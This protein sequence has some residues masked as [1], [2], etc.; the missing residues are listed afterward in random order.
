MKGIEAYQTPSDTDFHRPDTENGATLLKWAEHVARTLKGLNTLNPDKEPVLIDLGCG[1]GY[2]TLMLA[3]ILDIKHLVLIDGSN[4]MLNEARRLMYEAQLP[5][6]DFSFSSQAMDLSTD[7]VN[8][9]SGKTAYVTCLAV[10]GF[11]EKLDN[12]F[13]ET[14]RLL[15]PGGLFAFTFLANVQSVFEPKLV[16]HK[17]IDC[18]HH[19]LMAIEA[20]QD[21]FGFVKVFADYKATLDYGD[22]EA[23]LYEMYLVKK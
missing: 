4:A 23:R 1:A 5:R 10:M 9:E 3:E 14:H 13:A 8:F 21:K 12:L 7:A 20:L 15:M 6:K 2:R 16:P 19:S 17:G 22:H 11:L 18:Y